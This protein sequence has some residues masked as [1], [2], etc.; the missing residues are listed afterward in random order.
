MTIAIL[1]ITAAAL[2]LI[3]ILGLTISRSLQTSDRRPHA[4]Q[5]VDVDAFRNLVDPIE[6]EY[7]RRRL[8]ASDFRRVQRERLRATATYVQVAARNA[9]VL[10]LIGQA[11]LHAADPQTTEAARQLV[12]HALRLRRNAAFALLRIY[13][14]LPWPNSSPVA[15]SVLHGYQRLN[16]CAMLFGRLQNPAV[17]L[18]I[19]ATL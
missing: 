2:A 5:P 15:G 13:V 10:A 7:L 3:F 12:D 6:T 8:P 11:A 4:I 18:R 19:F 17:P 1:L 14:A 16:G 9:A